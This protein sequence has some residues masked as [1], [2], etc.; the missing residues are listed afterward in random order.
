MAIK[1]FLETGAKGLRVQH[2][3]TA[4][5]DEFKENEDLP[6]T[7]NPDDWARISGKKGER[8][9]FIRTLISGKTGSEAGRS[10]DTVANTGQYL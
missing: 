5:L 1:D 10:I 9:V 4:C 6:N 3:L 2:L 8:I 7:T